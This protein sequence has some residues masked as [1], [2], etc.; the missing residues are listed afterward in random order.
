M[1]LREPQTSQHLK[2]WH[3]GESK[4]LEAL[5]ESHLPWI[6]ERVRKRMGPLLRAKGESV[7][8]VQ[9]VV[10]EF[11]RYGPRFVLHEEAQ[12]RSL[13]CKIVENS[14]RNKHRWFVAA[15]RTV[16]REKPL[17]STTVLSLDRAVVSEKTPSISADRHER[18]A[19]V[20]LAMELL[21]PED[22]EILGL[23]NWQ[24]FTFNEIGE[25]IGIDAHAA[26]MRYHRAV[27]RL[28]SIVGDIRKQGISGVL[29]KESL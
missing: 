7:D 28:A 16:A 26:T 29:Q 5:L 9:D 23:R 24:K 21:P 25:R 4:S 12:F 10:V 3:Q 13:L 17:P 19:W 22:Q 27:R 2:S 8:Y 11:L 14:L 6:R 15:R 20:R 18:E 1:S